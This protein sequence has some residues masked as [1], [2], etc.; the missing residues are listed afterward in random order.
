[1][2]ENENVIS[3]NFTKSWGEFARGELEK[4]PTKQSLYMPPGPYSLSAG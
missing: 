3:Y 2:E 4:L 1:M